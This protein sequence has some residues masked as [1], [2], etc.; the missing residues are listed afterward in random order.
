MN[1]QDNDEIGVRAVVSGFE[2]AW[3]RHDMDAFGKLFATDAD[4]VNVRGIRWV[5]RE[6]IRNAHAA[7]HATIFKASTLKIEDTS[8]RFLTPDVATA[9]SV[10][11]LSGQSTPDG[12]V[13]PTRTTILTNVLVR[14]DGQWLI[15]LTQNTDVIK[16]GG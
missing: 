6:Q 13:V 1:T 4:F 11:T 15:V 2:A 16:P 14:T 12:Q 9:R 8:V 10:C 5:G 3:N 7:V